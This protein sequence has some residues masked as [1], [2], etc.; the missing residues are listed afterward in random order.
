VGSPVNAVDGN[1]EAQCCGNGYAVGKAGVTVRT[2][3]FADL[4]DMFGTD[5]KVH[6]SE[7]CDVAAL[8][9]ALSS[10][11]L[12]RRVLLD[13]DGA[14][15]KRVAILVNGRNTAFTGG[16]STPLKDGDLVDFFPPVFGG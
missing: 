5:D 9:A 7:A 6:L 16:G 13:E 10:S 3:F 8:L 2:R 11:P 1:L 12:R 4:R 14:S 15:G